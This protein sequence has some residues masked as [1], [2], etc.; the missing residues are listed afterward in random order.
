MIISQKF[1]EDTQNRSINIVPLIHIEKDSINNIYLSTNSLTFEDKYYNPILLNISSIRESLNLQSK[2][3]SISNMTIDISNAL[4]GNKRFSD[5]S[6]DLTNAIVTVYWKSP[7]T[8]TINECIR[9]F[10]GKIR[11]I[12]TQT[13]KIKLSIED[14]SQ[15]EMHKDVPISIM[16]NSENTTVTEKY[17]NTPIPMVYGYLKNSPVK[18]TFTPNANEADDDGFSINQFNLIIDRLPVMANRVESNIPDSNDPNEPVVDDQ[19]DPAG[20]Y[21]TV[22]SS[23][24]C[25]KKDSKSYYVIANN[26]NLGVGDGQIIRTSNGDLEDPTNPSLCFVSEYYLDASGSL[27]P[28]NNIAQGALPLI[29]LQSFKDATGNTSTSLYE[30]GW[31]LH[32]NDLSKL[33]DNRGN[34]SFLQTQIK[35]HSQ[36]LINFVAPL[37]SIDL[38][39]EDYFQSSYSP[40][41]R[42]TLLYR[43]RVNRLDK[44]SPDYNSGAIAQG[45]TIKCLY[46]GL[47]FN[48]FDVVGTEMATDVDFLY[49]SLYGDYG[50]PEIMLN[51]TFEESSI[52]VMDDIGHHSLTFQF[53]PTDASPATSSIPP[54]DWFNLAIKREFLIKKYYTQDFYVDVKGRADTTDNRIYTSPLERTRTSTSRQVDEIEFPYHENIL[55]QLQQSVGHGGKFFVYLNRYAP[56]T[57]PTQDGDVE[58]TLDSFMLNLIVSGTSITDDLAPIRLDFSQASAQFVD[59]PSFTGSYK[60]VAYQGLNTYQA[61]IQFE[62]YNYDTGNS[63]VW[64]T[65]ITDINDPFF[66]GVEVVEP[67]YGCTDPDANNYNPDADTDDGSCQYNP[68]EII[69]YSQLGSYV[70]GEEPNLYNNEYISVS[71]S[72]IFYTIV[73]ENE[74]LNGSNQEWNINHTHE[75]DN[76]FSGGAFGSYQN[77]GKY[78]IACFFQTDVNLNEHFGTF[79]VNID[80]IDGNGT[81]GSVVHT[82]LLENSLWFDPDQQEEEEVVE[83]YSTALIENPADIIHHLLYEEVGFDNN[84]NPVNLYE[85]DVARNAHKFKDF[86]YDI[87][88]ELWHNWKFA[89]NVSNKTNSKQL[90]TEI[91]KNTKLFPKLKNDGTFGF[92]CIR[93][94]YDIEG[95]YLSKEINN[96]DILSYSFSKTSTSKIYS[97]VKVLYNKNYEN[98]EY[99]SDTGWMYFYDILQYDVDKKQE[100]YDYYGMEE[101]FIN[102]DGDVQG[103]KELVFESDFIQD[104]DTAKAL[105]H[106]LLGWNMNSHNVLKIKLPINYLTLEIG[107]IIYFDEMISGI[108]VNGED[109]SRNYVLEGKGDESGNGSQN[110]ITR[111]YQVIYPL[112]II[113]STNKTL[114]DVSI[115][116]VQ[117]HD[118]TGS[119]NM[120]RSGEEAPEN[121]AYLDI[122]NQVVLNDIAANLPKNIMKTD[123]EGAGMTSF[124]LKNETVTGTLQKT[125]WDFSIVDID[126]QN[127]D[128][129]LHYQ[130]NSDGNWIDASEGSYIV[131][132]DGNIDDIKFKTFANS[133]NQEYIKV[134]MESTISTG[135]DQEYTDS[136]SGNI[137]T[138]LAGDMNKDY[139]IDV[140]DVVSQV[141]LVLASGNLG[142]DVD[143]SI[144]YFLGDINNDGLVNVLDVVSLVYVILGN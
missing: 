135:S 88:S 102:E 141:Q 129:E 71:E 29:H 121:F 68:L 133:G 16:T 48:T 33:T 20:P 140:L 124:R 81:T 111:N 42:A 40:L 3:Y 138:Y 51:S 122:D 22:S 43:F 80:V 39:L 120:L 57:V 126:G 76:G 103:G 85:K 136:N 53:A 38:E 35:D 112:F 96:D 79:T 19:G 94:L 77:D 86:Y 84:I 34:T 142:D 1:I 131:E 60:A 72:P 65:T 23:G 87:N 25:I 89:F 50:H 54:V 5:Y 61:R 4:V 119:L 24:V 62:N 15:D 101:E 32:A 144:N 13:N 8:N 97:R 110:Y 139:N 70:V 12:S 105:R 30:N 108:K 83:D 130:L 115:E 47:G 6:G 106:Y 28:N 9:V 104:R 107:D 69:S 137:Q 55:I 37:E 117:I 73:F 14:Y 90:I 45:Y 52:Q 66:M 75:I 132:G 17:L 26:S 99:L 49:D 143:S 114:Q 127:I 31:D 92:S 46:D 2:N 59:L 91:S 27:V 36:R 125:E 74:E 100:Y 56:I 18:T 44:Q 98:D 78:V 82:F 63:I 67:V 116:A 11:N 123:L 10:V 113:T 58:T 128:K 7:N 95:D 134:N 41:S 21:T 93:D 118:W 64:Y 109:Y